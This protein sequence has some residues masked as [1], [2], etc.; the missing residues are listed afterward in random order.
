MKYLKIFTPISFALFY[1]LT[2]GCDKVPNT[3]T[4]KPINTDTIFDGRPKIDTATP[5]YLNASG[6]SYRNTIASIINSDG[7]V[8][9]WF[10][11]PGNKYPNGLAYTSMITYNK[12]SD[13]GKT[14]G[15]EAVSLRPTQGNADQL[16]CRDPAVVKLSDGYY[17]IAYSSSNVSES[18]DNKIYIG[19]S[20]NPAGPWDKWNGTKWAQDS[21]VAIVKDT[22]AVA[23]KY[24]GAGAPSLI[25]LNNVLYLYYTFQPNTGQSFIKLYTS[26]LSDTNWPSKLVSMGT[27]LDKSMYYVSKPERA[28]VKYREDI[29]KFVALFSVNSLTDS[30]YI[31][32]W[33]SSD[34]LFFSRSGSL[35]Y[36]LKIDLSGCGLSSDENGFIQSNTKNFITYSV[37]TSASKLDAYLNYYTY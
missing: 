23:K 3:A 18:I 35:R 26:D 27:V 32:Y 4:S 9:A 16:F 13:G 7:S 20:E 34:G 11:T 30:S 10:T 25:V 33:Q 28:V 36:N 31:S 24:Y 22:A 37:G 14:W 15:T 29:K 12:S 21:S 1:F 17:Y 6:S 19:R 5:I 2:T 8:D